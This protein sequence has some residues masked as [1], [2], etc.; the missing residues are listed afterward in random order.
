MKLDRSLPCIA[1]MSFAD[2]DAFAK[3]AECVEI[4]AW[5]VRAILR[6]E[7]LT[8][9]VIDPCCGP[10]IMAEIAAAA[11]YNVRAT[12]FHDW[13]YGEIR[14]V[15]FLDPAYPIPVRGHTVLMNPPFS[16][17]CEFIDAARARGARKVVCF[18]RA[19]FWESDERKDWWPKNLPQRFYACGDRAE[20][21]RVTI[22]AD[23][24]KHPGYQ[25]HGFY[26]WEEGQPAGPIM[27]HIWDDSPA[28]KRKGKRKVADVGPR[29]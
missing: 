7:I 29:L 20:C 27:G 11:A 4:D 21:W 12:D 17:A 16:L 19:A 2:A 10:G 5:A 6:A 22:P 13:G 8:P 15:S 28:R 24:R 1:G 14:D 18:Q 26:V 25:P 3:A 23:D 9:I